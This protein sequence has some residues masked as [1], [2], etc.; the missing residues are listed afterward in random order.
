MSLTPSALTTMPHD[1]KDN[2][3]LSG[4]LEASPAEQHYRVQQDAERDSDDHSREF[5]M[6]QRVG[7]VVGP[8]AF[9]IM[10][11]LPTP[12]GMSWEAQRVAAVTLLMATWWISEAIPIPATSLLPIMLF[13]LLGV[14]STGQATSGYA[15]HLIFLFMGGF[16]IA[17]AMQRWDLHRRIALHVIRVT[18]FSPGRLV[19]GFMLATALLSAFVSNTATTV[20]MLP[21]GMAVVQQMF[22]EVKASGRENREAGMRALSLNLMLGIAYAASIGGIATLIGTP[23]NTVLASYLAKTYDYEITFAKWLMV[24]VPLVCVFLP[25]VWIWLTRVANPMPGVEIPNAKQVIDAELKEMG[26]MQAGERWTLFVFS[27]TSCGWIFRPQLAALFPEPGMIKDASIAIA[28]ALILFVI[29]VQFSKRIFVMDWEWAAKLPWGVLILFGGGLAL[30]EGFQ[31]SGLASFIVGQITI[32][33][34]LPIFVVVLCVT[35]LVIFLT[36]LTSNTA[37][38]TML[39]P[40]LAGIAIGLGQSPLIL[41]APAALAA[42]CAFMLPVATPPNAIVFGS[43][44]VTIP[45][46]VRSG[47]AL[48]IIGIILIPL[49]LYFLFIPVFEIVLGNLPDWAQ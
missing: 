28:G 5:G 4:V 34:N 31:V 6:R 33:E 24:G 14:M 46:M 30:A 45:Q 25:L 35:A 23:P 3:D 17:L 8:L 48:N 37:T 36:E 47:F 2:E 1:P 38:S 12:E 29:P 39:M 22:A 20:M 27:L 13:P 10:L 44:H 40:V 32:F 49:C 41:L 9:L 7:L 42:S 15:N 11:L 43:G 21:I 26:K 18:G 19:F 16:I